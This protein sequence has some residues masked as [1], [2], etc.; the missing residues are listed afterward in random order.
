MLVKR[1]DSQEQKHHHEPGHEAVGCAIGA[2]LAKFLNRVRQHV[3]DADRQH[4]AGNHTDDHL[5]AR[6]RNL[7]SPRKP[8][9]EERRAD[10]QGAIDSQNDSRSGD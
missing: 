1:K 9:A 6:V 10:E 2:L 8:T 3:K 4:Q 7:Q 5:H